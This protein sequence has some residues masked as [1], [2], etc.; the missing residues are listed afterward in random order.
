MSS[1]QGPGDPPPGSTFSLA[2][3][4]DVL[5]QRIEE[6]VLLDRLDGLLADEARASSEGMEALLALGAERFGVEHGVLARVDPATTTH[7]VAH[8]SGDHPELRDGTTTALSATVDRHVI[9]RKGALAVRRDAASESFDAFGLATYFGAKVVVDGSLYGTLAFVDRTPRDA[10]FTA[11]DAAVLGLLVQAVGRGLRRRRSAPTQ[12]QLRTVFEE[13]PSMINVHDRAG[14]LLLPNPRLCRKTGYTKEELTQMKV[15]DLDPNVTPERARATWADMAPGERRHWESR[16]RRK[17]GSTFP[18]EVTLRRLEE[19]EADRF[20]VTSRDITERKAAERALR[21]SKDLHRETL[22][23]ITDAVFVT[24]EDGTFTYVCP[25]VGY[26]FKRS[27]EEV[28]ALGSISALLGSDPTANKTFG[29]DPE[30]SN[31]E[32]RVVDAEGTPHDLLINVRR[33]DIQGGTRMYTCRDITARK[34]TERALER[35]NDL[36]E[37]AQSLAGVGAWEYDVRSGESTWTDETYRIY[38]LPN[39]SPPP[40]ETAI[41]HFHPDDRPT[42]RDAFARAVEEGE[43]YDLELRLIGADHEQRWVHTRGEPQTDDG[44]VVRVRGSIQDV[45]ARRGAEEDRRATRRLLEKTVESLGE[46]VLVVDP[47]GRRIVE[48]NAAVEEVFGYDPNELVGESTERLH[49]SPAAYE[50]FG[51]LSEAALNED[52]IF[53]HDYEMR[54]KDGQIIKTEHVVT[55]LDD[56]W[57]QGVVSVV[58]DVTEQREAEAELRRQR[59]QLSMAVEGGN[60]GTWNWDLDTDRVVFNRQWAEMLGYTR[61]ELPF[62]YST[63]ETLVHP[64]DLDRALDD[65]QDYLE[66][67]ADTFNPHIRMRTKSGEWKWIQTIGKVLERD[68]AGIPT[69]AAGIHLDIHER[70]QA[71]TALQEREAQLRGLAHSIP[72]VVFQFFARADGTWGNHFVSDRAESILGLSPDA[73][74]FLERFVEQIPSSHRDDFVAS[75]EAAVDHEQ[76]WHFETPFR[77]PSGDRIWLLGTSTPTRR[78]DQLVF[79]GVLL[80]IT[81]RREARQA[82]RAERDRF[83]TLFHNLPTPVAHG[84]TDDENRVRVLAVNEAFEAAFGY[85]EDDIRGENLGDRIVPPED[86]DEAEVLRRRLLAGRSVNREVRRRA[87][88]GVRDFRVQVALRDG[89]DGPLEGSEI[90]TD[91]TDRKQR[92]RALARRKALLEAQAEATIDGLLVVD[93]DRHVVFSNDRFRKIWELSPDV[94]RPDGGSPPSEPTVFGEVADR[95]RHP[96]AF[97]EAVEHLHEHPDEERR[98]LVRL[99]DGRWLDCYST[100]IASDEGT[101]FGRLWVFRDV[102]D[103]RRMQERLLE[104][105]EKERRR[106][107]QEIHDEMGGLLTSLQFT[108]GLARRQSPDDG[109]SA[110]H[111]D[112]IEALVD[113]LASVTRTISRKLYPSELSD[114]GLS[115]SL[116]SLADEMDEQHDLTVDLQCD[117]EPGNR[118]S[119][120]I[121]RTAY[122]IVQEAL[123]NA[124]R[125]AETGTAQV[126]VRLCG[127]RLRLRISDEGVGFD[128]STSHGAESFGLEGIRRRVERLNGTLDL[129]TGPGEGTHIVVLLP[130][131]TTSGTPS[132]RPTVD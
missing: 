113:D 52:G 54:R 5:A 47:S 122:W 46:A 25:N 103:R 108:L 87:A 28:E 45:T 56:D 123:L 115:G 102:T 120:L 50:R 31:I 13:A 21:R 42:L 18:V 36:F 29:D 38:G 130:L 20:V 104:V 67:D 19:A 6:P 66:G 97:R 57:R 88:D 118:F 96:D 110:E 74:D 116:S 76:P 59:E 35:R 17:D 100:P 26:I 40:V 107:D 84:R 49:K 37:Q 121:E 7:T 114:Y 55:P 64:D 2:S 32:H 58:R 131:T 94:L 60:I 34:E 11:T 39:D 71:R 126:A 48:C 3:D 85:A 83:A 81:D 4:W 109:A 24:R 53:R 23:N 10:A 79:N 93:E 112:Q 99:T 72:G 111:V 65:L 15:W 89:T 68:E 117:V 43:P 8:A 77:R 14:T 98:D 12:A 62:A 63:W 61:E 73:D 92:E 119:S 70:K 125:H 9:V 1:S 33:V 101:H 22:R 30:I 16:Y 124:A 127:G 106:I 95:L 27:P 129:D 90:Y 51:R 105:Q 80:D 128:P 82:L 132:E 69:R 44:E 41:R 75:I 78:D 91:I 86:R